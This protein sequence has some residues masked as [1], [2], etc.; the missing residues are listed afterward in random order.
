[1][2]GRPY[3]ANVRAEKGKTDTMKDNIAKLDWG[4]HKGIPGCAFVVAAAILMLV[5]FAC[6][7]KKQPNPPANLSNDPYAHFLE[8]RENLDE[9]K[10]IEISPEDAQTRALLGC[11]KE[12]AE[13]TIDGI[14]QIAYEG[15][16]ENETL[17]YG[18]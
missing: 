8:M 18:I 9:D 4:D 10:Q 11:G 16:C 15:I 13:D 17:H 7:E 2:D 5:L 14:L 1:M 12:W 3:H 6:E